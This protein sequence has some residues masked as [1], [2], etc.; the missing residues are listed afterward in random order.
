MSEKGEKTP[1]DVK[2]DLEMLSKQITEL[3]EGTVM[4]VSAAES[5]RV[6]RK[7]DFWSVLVDASSH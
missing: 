3:N 2:A 7:I 1:T 4:E 5:K 6:L